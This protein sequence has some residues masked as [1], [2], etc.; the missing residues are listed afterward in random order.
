MAHCWKKHKY[1]E[2]GQ[3]HKEYIGEYRVYNSMVARCYKPSTDAYKTHGARGTRV[4]PRWLDEQRGFINFFNDMGVRPKDEKG[5]HYQ[6]DRIDFNGDYC[7]ENCRWVSPKEQ[8]QN[9]R[10]NKYAYLYGDKLCL[11][12]ICRLLHIKRTT[13][14]EAIRTRGLSAEEAIINGLKCKY[15]ENLYVC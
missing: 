9:R 5:R 6:I 14:S 1:S 13:V 15:K 12:E 7:P 4:C 11:S 10:N 3:S 8:Q 2:I